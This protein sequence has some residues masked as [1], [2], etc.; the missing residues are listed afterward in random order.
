MASAGAAAAAAQ[1]LKKPVLLVSPLSIAGDSERAKGKERRVKAERSKKR[2][3][4]R[5]QGC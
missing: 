4:L 5:A 1:E 2:D 3:G